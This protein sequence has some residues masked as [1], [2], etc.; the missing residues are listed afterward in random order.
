MQAATSQGAPMIFDLF[1]PVDQFNL[2][3]TAAL[4]LDA[5]VKP[6]EKLCPSPKRLYH[7]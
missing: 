5:P 3:F 4:G 2:F 6:L 1:L 7:A